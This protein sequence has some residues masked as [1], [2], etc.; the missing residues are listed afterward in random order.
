MVE[1]MWLRDWRNSPKGPTESL[2]QSA[3]SQGQV[4]ELFAMRQ[5]DLETIK[6]WIGLKFYYRA[7]EKVKQEEERLRKL[8]NF[9]Q[10]KQ[11]LLS[12]YSFVLVQTFKLKP[13]N[14]ARSDPW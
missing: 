7:A 3:L 13:S 6:A 4:N 2:E 11:T 8:L 14:V 1:W 9:Q 10:T 5:Q 12:E